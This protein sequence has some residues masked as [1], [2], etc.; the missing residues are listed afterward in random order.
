MFTVLH[1]DPARRTLPTLPPPSGLPTEAKR[2]TPLSDNAS[3]P[4]SMPRIL[5][6]V[7]LLLA[8]VGCQD[9]RQPRLETAADSLAFRVTEAAGGLEAWESLH[10]L[11]FE[12]AVVSDSTERIRTRH[13]W[14]KHGGRVRSEWPGGADSVFVAVFRPDEFDEAAPEGQVALNGVALA[15]DDAGERL[16]EANGRFVN[17]G[18]WLLAP[19]KVLDPGVRRTIETDRGR[20]RLA[21]AFD[22]VGLTPG[23]RY[24]ID[25]DPVSGAMT[26]WSFVLESGNEG[27][28]QW[29]DPAR[30]ATDEGPLSLSRMHVS[31]DGQTV[32]LTEPTGLGDE[33]DESEFTDL[34]PRLRPAP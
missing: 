6:L 15:G 3:P 8:V 1:T 21:I 31:A 18:Y 34:T 26:G 27:E 25:V 28:W 14:D 23:D 22:G 24:W 10:G 2:P 5:F 7:S 30:I 32:I 4:P 13:V 9:A 33:I 11:E 29:A 17:D 12:W 19:L 16:V 20:D